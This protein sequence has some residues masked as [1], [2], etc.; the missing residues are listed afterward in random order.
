MEALEPNEDLWPIHV[1]VVDDET[2]IR[3]LLAD[4]LRDAGF[5][6][7]E[8]VNADEA[9]DY[10][11]ARSDIDLVFTDIRMPGSMNGLELAAV[12]HDEDP[13][14]PII[15]TSGNAGPDG[16]CGL[17]AFLPKPYKMADAVSL[18]FRTL[19]IQ[20]PDSNRS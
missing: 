6:V 17:G 2:L 7:V 16:A 9:L 14:L 3:S 19:G 4:E 11:S 5:R 18:V 15:I 12:L 20:P 8:A 13:S 1:L 10:M